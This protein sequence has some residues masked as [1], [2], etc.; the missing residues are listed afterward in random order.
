MADTEAGSH[1]PDVDTAH[2][3]SK[4]TTSDASLAFQDHAYLSYLIPAATDLELE[5]LFKNVDSGK[6]VLDSIEQRDGVFFG[7]SGPPG[8]LGTRRKRSCHLLI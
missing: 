5:D 6:P 4:E 7:A 2:L 3:H 8:L 1:V